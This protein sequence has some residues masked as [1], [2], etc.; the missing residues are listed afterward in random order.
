[1]IEQQH[2]PVSEIHLLPKINKAW[3]CL[4]LHPRC[5]G[6]PKNSTRFVPFGHL[7]HTSHDKAYVGVDVWDAR[8]ACGFSTVIRDLYPA[9][10]HLLK[11]ESLMK[12]HSKFCNGIMSPSDHESESSSDSIGVVH[13]A[14]CPY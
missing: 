13:V 7:D 3:L 14:E 4:T 1:M 6:Y 10:L 9:L 5:S 8:D 12:A 11:V 2:K